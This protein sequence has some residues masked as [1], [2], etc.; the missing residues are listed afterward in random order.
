M[1]KTIAISIFLFFLSNRIIAQSELQVKMILDSLEVLKRTGGFVG[2]YGIPPTAEEMRLH[3]IT[4]M[5]LELP[6]SEV[7]KMMTDD[8]RFARAYGFS[9]ASE[10]Y[11]DS[12][13]TAE[14][15]LFDDTARLPLYTPQRIIDEGITLGQ[16]CEMIYA[17]GVEKRKNAAREKDVIAAVKQFIKDSSEYPDSYNPATFTNYSWGGED[18]DFF[19]EIQHQ[20][21]LKQ[22]DGKEVEVVN[23][24]VLDNQVK[25]MLI[26][27]TRSKV[28]KVSPP[29]INEWVNKFGK[30]R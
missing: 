10:R 20:Y 6:F 11:F 27:T 17:A 26:E 13:T 16:L 18:D 12:L 9:V 8:D 15:K 2:G 21:K 3:N 19:F 22:T 4:V 23:Y 24:F 1:I 29:A 25:V 7:K 5:L 14:L 28:V 30:K